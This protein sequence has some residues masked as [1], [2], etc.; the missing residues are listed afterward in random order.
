MVV[1]IEAGSLLRGLLLLLL[2]PLIAVA[3]IFVSESLAIQILIIV[4][5]AGLPI[6]DIE[7]ASRALLP[8]FYAAEEYLGGDK[9]LGTEIELNP[10]TKKATGFVK[11]P[12][13][14][15]GKWKKLAVM[16]EFGEKSPDIGVR[17]GGVEL[18]LKTRV[19]KRR[20]SHLINRPRQK[21]PK[22]CGTSV[23]TPPHAK[24]GTNWEEKA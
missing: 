3:Y 14:L 6:R 7:L 15:V 2:F 5:F 13:V 1:E 17:E 18:T 9:V 21:F 4:S 10:K 24:R 20:T 16:K 11:K 8:R 19:T 12:G 23:N 22:R